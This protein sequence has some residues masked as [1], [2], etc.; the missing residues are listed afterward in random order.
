MRGV[1]EGE[2]REAAVV[3]FVLLISSG[4]CA[5]GASQSTKP[6]TPVPAAPP[7]ATSTATTAMQ[8][9]PPQAE[10]AGPL[11]LYEVR[12][13]E[14]AGQ[15]SVLFRF[16]RPPEGIDYFPLRNPS[17]LVIDVKGSI[18]PLSKIRSYKAV[19]SSV[20]AVRIG[21]YQGRMRLVVDL[22]G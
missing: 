15:R 2:R 17:R 9:P 4:A 11:R 1:R 6:T 14:T 22:K 21:N 8:T 12:V 18:E 10:Y 7:T 20:T 3:L 19:N 16:S 5:Q 13:S